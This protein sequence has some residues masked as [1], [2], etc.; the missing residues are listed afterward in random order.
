MGAQDRPAVLSDMGED[1][2]SSLASKLRANRSI[3][4]VLVDDALDDALATMPRDEYEALRKRL[5]KLFL[6]Q[7]RT[8]EVEKMLKD[9][10][11]K[12]ALATVEHMVEDYSPKI[13]EKLRAWLADSWEAVTENAAK[14]MLSDI[15]MGVGRTFLKRTEAACAVVADEGVDLH[16]TKKDPPA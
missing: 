15:L 12:R 11:H 14:H 6:E 8:V 1:V 7:F 3:L 10:V 5:V 4:T 13:E 16:G 9:R 2:Y